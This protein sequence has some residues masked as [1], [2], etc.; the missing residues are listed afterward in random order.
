MQGK[1]SILLLGGFRLVEQDH[2]ITTLTS[3]NL[4]ILL[5]YLL[6]HRDTPH[7]RQQLAFLFYPDSSEAQAQSNFRT[8]LG[9]LRQAWHGAEHYVQ[10]N[11]RTIQW[12]SDASFLL[13]VLEFENA[14]ARA[15][16]GGGISE[17]ERAVELYR[18]DL[19]PQCYAD[20]ILPIRERLRQKYLN[21]LVQL[22]ELLKAQ[23]D[24]HAALVYAQQLLQLE[25]LQE[26]T[27]Q[28][29][30]RLHAA[31][32][33]R[34]SMLRVFRQ[35][36]LVLHQELRAEP[37][38]ETR[39]LF[40]QL[41]H[42]EPAK[43]AH[44][45]PTRATHN[46]PT[47]LTRFVGRTRE[48]LQVKQLLAHTRL[49]TLIGAGG[50][51]KTRLA[52][53]IA[54]A[55]IK[56]EN[57]AHAY[58]HGVW[59]VELASLYD[60]TLVAQAVAAALEIPEQPG[61][62]MLETLSNALKARELLLILDNCEHLIAACADLA[63]TLLV[64]SPHLQIL[65]TSR[66]PLDIPGEKIYRVPTL[67][68]A[69]SNWQTP[70]E[71]DAVSLFVERAQAVLPTFTLTREN[72]SYVIQLCQRLDG[73]PLAIELA[74]A[75]VKL[76][77][78]PELARR[79]ENR[80]DLLTGGNRIALPRHQTLRAALDW[81]YDL[82]PE[83]EQRLFR[84]LATFAGGWTYE[85][86]QQVCAHEG[87]GSSDL[88]DLLAR[89]LD[90][91]LVLMEARGGETRYA[92]L[93]TLRAYA[94]EKLEQ[95]GEQ[96]KMCARHLEYFRALAETAQPQLKRAAQGEWLARL[97][98][99]RD[100]FRVALQR[101]IET[102]HTPAALDLAAR[103]GWFWFIHSEFDE[104][105]QWLA[106][107]ASLSDAAQFPE[108]YAAALA[109]L[110]HHIWMQLGAAQA[111]PF[112]ERALA[113]ARANGD[114]PNIAHALIVLGLCLT[115]LRDF[116]AACGAFGESR[117]L[118]QELGD[119][120][121]DAH[122]LMG[123]GLEAELDGNGPASLLLHTQALTIFQKLGD[124]FFSSVALRQIGNR[125]LKQG[126]LRRAVAALREALSHAQRLDSQFEMAMLL[127]RFG[128]AAQ[129]AGKPERA[130]TLYAAAKTMLEALGAF[131]AQD[132][133]AFQAIE[134]EMD[135]TQALDLA[136]SASAEPA[137][138]TENPNAISPG[139]WEMALA[140]CRSA[141]D[142]TTFTAA[143]EQGRAFSP[144]QAVAYAL[145]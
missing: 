136:T 62:A 15:E 38:R 46:V 80:F 142:D 94:S 119:E 86:A 108:A 45:F 128:Q 112:A 82:L 79:M 27:Y 40:E 132:D 78:M 19:L 16:A 97:V 122:A 41:Q 14:L 109:Q 5:A 138:P 50:S 26:T 31:Q 102:Q 123:L 4:Q 89:L 103:L 95:S 6:L 70:S 54:H 104:G 64:H 9:R 75:R 100:N 91:S 135:A 73:I 114:K 53:E 21:A 83:N 66:E 134:I 98:A 105:R 117:A 47:P 72:A 130:L 120:W 29:L 32:G 101:A 42:A 92:M 56:R 8:L 13:D 81:S 74:A 36:E 55:G 49:L 96:E 51:G 30:M 18:G 52:L 24:Y 141:L 35:C 110:A 125:Y 57:D 69:L 59:W 25:P 44:P 11:N 76:F 145:I 22:I 58:K 111:R 68:V 61:R 85:A 67:T 113:V 107:A 124:S 65:A 12:R 17:L 71:S 131:S 63:H 99:E 7:T 1:L 106:R 48:M 37:S 33:D 116:S 23:G 77:S 139:D 60:E 137:A 3:A 88:V 10:I 144:E 127:W 34:S 129:L 43:R 90:K 84:R 121:C 118:C 39:A 2:I 20:W 115:V 133:A 93:D 140:A 143:L 87:L 126:E 28:L